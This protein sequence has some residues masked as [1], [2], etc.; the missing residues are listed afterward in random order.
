M[1]FKTL[2]QVAMFLL[3]HVKYSETTIYCFSL[4]M[5]RTPSA[6]EAVGSKGYYIVGE[7]FSPLFC[8]IKGNQV[9]LM[10]GAE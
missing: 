4:V 3:K 9:F 2:H 10:P 8:I 1:K 6:V 5:K 7:Y